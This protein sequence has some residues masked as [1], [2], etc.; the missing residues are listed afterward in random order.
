[1]RIVFYGTTSGGFNPAVERTMLPNKADE[2]EAVAKKYP[3]HE[4]IIMSHLPGLYIFDVKGEGICKYP[5]ADNVK[6]VVMDKERTKDEIIDK[7]AEYKPDIAI[8][9]A[10]AGTPHDWNPIKETMIA[11]G[12]EARGIPT[13]AQN[14]NVSIGSFDKWRTN[15]MLRS[16]GVKIAK[17]VYV[18]HE[19]F[20]TE[21]RNKSIKDNVYKE[22]VF[23][24]IHK[25][26]FPI[27]I[28]DTLGSGSMGIQIARSYD[29]AVNI[30]NAD[31]LDMDVIAEELIEGEQFGT[32]IHGVKGRYS[33]LPPFAFSTNQ[34][35]ITDP[36]QSVKYGPV[37]DKRYGI[38][39]LQQSLIAMAEELGLAG[40]TQVDLVYKAGEWYVIELNPRWSGMTTTAAAAEGRYAFEIFLES[41]LGN[42][43]N[44]SKPMNV[45]Y[46]MN[47]KIP[48]LS[49][50]DLDRL[51]KL[52]FVK[53]VMQFH[54]NIPGR[55]EVFYSEIVYGGAATK[56][57]LWEEF[58]EIDR[59]FPNIISESTKKNAKTLIEKYN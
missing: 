49:D 34:D 16:A 41:V 30:L 57:E 10:T 3:E 29:E 59:Q 23:D 22:Y 12:L 4:F 33:V 2:W 54:M 21:K 45:K 27:I 46:V 15:V 51:G 8:A 19:L 50:E 13:L 52:P 6:Y 20:V 31:E 14:M 7:I 36:F 55:P 5:N 47:F 58:C 43:K 26:T 1:M 25:M 40:T 35:G 38:E 11:E 53:N 17:G 28:K 56:E 39:K 18:H 9:I 32:E 44:Y 48:G 24:R 37:T 42:D